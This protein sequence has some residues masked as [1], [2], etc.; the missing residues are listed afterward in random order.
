M[1]GV[2]ANQ[3]YCENILNFVEEVKASFA[4]E[5]QM[6]QKLTCENLTDFV[7]C[8]GACEGHGLRKEV[9]FS[10]T[11]LLNGELVRIPGNKEGMKWSTIVAHGWF[12]YQLKLKSGQENVIQITA[13]SSTDSLTMKVTIGTKEYIVDKTAE[14]ANGKYVIALKYQASTEEESAVVKIEK[15]SANMPLVYTMRVY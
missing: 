12:S 6:V 10:D 14:S 9:N 2:G 4:Y 1:G 13:G 8:G 3:G 15:I 11:L 5:A 7:V